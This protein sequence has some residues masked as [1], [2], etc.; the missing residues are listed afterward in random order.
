MMP[1]SNGYTT[2]IPAWH[3]NTSELYQWNNN[4][5]FI[6]QN[7]SDNIYLNLYVYNVYAI[8]NITLINGEINIYDNISLIS[9]ITIENN[10]ITYYNPQN[11]TNYT[12]IY[13]NQPYNIQIIV[14][15][16]NSTIFIN[17]YTFN[18]NYTATNIYLQ[19]YSM[20]CEIEFTSWINENN[21]Y[22]INSNF[23]FIV[24]ILIF[25]LLSFII[26]IYIIDIRV[27]TNE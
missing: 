1:I 3:G 15:P 6:P 22:I 16:D 4:Y 25:I 9:L 5:Y 19:V 13:I 27:N 2:N 23:D 12:S 18:F 10:T 26:V 24:Y 8:E 20:P 7:Y 21:N 17:N 14:Y 11:T